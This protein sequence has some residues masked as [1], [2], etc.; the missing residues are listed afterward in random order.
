VYYLFIEPGRHA[1]RHTI[2]YLKPDGDN[3]FSFHGR[4]AAAPLRGH[5]TCAKNAP[6]RNTAAV[7]AQRNRWQPTASG[8][9]A[10]TTRTRKRCVTT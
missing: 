9:W 7:S 4:A 2:L 6:P 3:L 8:C 5:L 10:P 1:G